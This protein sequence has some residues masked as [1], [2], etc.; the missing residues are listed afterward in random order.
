[1]LQSILIKPDQ[2]CVNCSVKLKMLRFSDDEESWFIGKPEV[3]VELRKASPSN[4]A[5][6]DSVHRMEIQAYR[7]FVMMHLEESGSYFVHPSTFTS[8]SRLMSVMDPPPGPGKVLSANPA[9]LLF[10]PILRL[11]LLGIGSFAISNE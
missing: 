11:K 1:M 7:R 4:P 8:R 6:K 2:K 3:E 9:K 5:P 10:V